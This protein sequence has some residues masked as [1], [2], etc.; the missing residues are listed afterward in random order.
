VSVVGI[1]AALDVGTRRIPNALTLGGLLLAL[2]LRGLEGTSVLVAGLFGALLAFALTL[3]L[4]LL[5]GMGGGD[6]K[7]LTA[8]GGFLGPQGLLVAF[9]ATAVVGGFL[10]VGA[11]IMHRRLAASL[12][13]VF[14]LVRGLA[15]TAVAGT[16]TDSVPNLTSRDAIAVPYGVAI[17]IGAVVGLA[18]T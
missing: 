2:G 16:G 11:A 12:T 9:L 13:G 7:L 8:V 1:A 15:L 3:P 17:A 18:L 14:R 6:V 10:A 4:F 5:K